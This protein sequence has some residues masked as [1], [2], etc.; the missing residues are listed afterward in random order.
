MAL[1]SACC[2]SVVVVSFV[3]VLNIK[4]PL[5]ANPG[6]SKASKLQ[7]DKFFP[8]TEGAKQQHKSAYQQ[9]GTKNPFSKHWFAEHMNHI[10]F[11]KGTQLP[12]TKLY[13][14]VGSN[15]GVQVRKLFNPEL[16]PGANV[17]THFLQWFGPK[18]S[19]KQKVCAF[20]FEPDP[21]HTKR[22][23]Q[24][25][26]TYRSNGYCVK[27][28][29]ETAVG[30]HDDPVTLYRDN[31]THHLRW[32]SSTVSSKNYDD[33]A[34]Q[35]ITV[36]QVN[37]SDFLLGLKE[38]NGQGTQAFLKPTVVMKMDIEGAEYKI[39]PNLIQTGAL[40]MINY[41][42]IEWHHEMRNFPEELKAKAAYMPTKLQAAASKCDPRLEFER[43]D[44]ESYLRDGIPLR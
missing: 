11:Q 38:R 24:L 15:I 44:D 26:K 36:H 43:L 27:V 25:E 19:R 8:T 3:L 12:Y 4:Y 28:F 21:S 9:L 35:S 39:L 1:Q 33:S 30:I 23:L 13:L 7:T 14:D 18:K 34:R 41:L 40:C 37:L 5:L 2:I 42:L 22:L 10:K 31:D 29:P 17:H 32:G 16:Y 20:A 6:R